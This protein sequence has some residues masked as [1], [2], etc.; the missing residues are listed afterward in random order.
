[1]LI[2]NHCIEIRCELHF[3]KTVHFVWNAV[4]VS[5]IVI[6]HAHS[7]CEKAYVH[8]RIILYTNFE[9]NTLL[10]S[11]KNSVRNKNAFKG[12][13]SRLSSRL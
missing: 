7:L 5:T 12:M 9:P 4:D 3:Y 10:L 11:F 1:M 8:R 2:W 13:G 6:I